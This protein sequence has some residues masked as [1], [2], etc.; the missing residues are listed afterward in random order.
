MKTGFLDS[1]GGGLK[2]TKRINSEDSL[3]SEMIGSSLDSG[4]DLA[5]KICNLENQLLDGKSVLLGDDGKPLTP[6]IVNRSSVDGDGR[7]FSYPSVVEVGNVI[8]TE[9]TMSDEAMRTITMAACKSF[10]EVMSGVAS[11]YMP[12]DDKVDNIHVTKTIAEAPLSYASKISPT[13]STKA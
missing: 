13:S 9:S 12:S 4:A 2:K 1:G 8:Q 10:E 3:D 7:V 6:P 11:A 5:S